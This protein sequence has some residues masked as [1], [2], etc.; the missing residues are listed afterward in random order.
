MKKILTLFACTAALALTYCGTKTENK[1]EEN[2][3][4]A[5]STTSANAEAA[6]TERKARIMQERK[7]F[8]ERRRMAIEDRAKSS[9]TYKDSKGR[10]VYNSAEAMPS[11]HGSE[12][13]LDQYIQDNIN[14][15]TS[16]QADQVEGTVFV[17]FV[18][19]ADGVVRDAEV[20]EATSDTVKKSFSEEAVRV[21]SGMP[22]WTPG[23]QGGKP[24]DV[25]VSLP[26]TFQ[27]EM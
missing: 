1:V 14:Y 15:P 19:G 25:R 23:T 3:T 12:D 22:A 9:P 17:E 7:E 10:L 26:I 27:L 8:A 16:A 18:V 21:V 5:D 4:L 11:F 20:I 24:V 13:E 2:I 6:R